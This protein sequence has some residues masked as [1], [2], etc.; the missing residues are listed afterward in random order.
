MDAAAS[1]KQ[2]FPPEDQSVV[3]HLGQFVLSLSQ[4]FS[5]TGYYRPGQPT[6]AARQRLYQEWSQL[7]KKD[8]EVSLI[9]DP[10][11]KGEGLLIYGILSEGT[12]LKA[13]FSE[14]MGAPFVPKFRDYF[15]SRRLV[16]FSLKPEIT[17]EEFSSF[18]EIMSEPPLPTA[19]RERAI[20]EMTEK[21]IAGQIV[22][23]SI[24]HLE[25]FFAVSPDFNWLTRILLARLQE[26]LRM[27]PLHKQLSETEK[28]RC[29]VR[30]FQTVLRP[31]THTAVL[32][33]ILMQCGSVP[34]PVGTG[35]VRLEAEICSALYPAQQYRLLSACA[36]DL[37]RLAPWG[38]RGSMPAE[39]ESAYQQTVFIIRQLVPQFV[40]VKIEEGTEALLETLIQ[41][42]IVAESELSASLIQRIDLVR[43]ANRYRKNPEETWERLDA[44]DA[45]A[46]HDRVALLPVLL[47]QN[48][49]QLFGTL[50][51]QMRIRFQ[52]TG[53]SDAAF[54]DTAC[55]V[56]LREALLSKLADRRLDNRKELLPIVEPF[57][58]L[59][60]QD[61]LPRCADEDIWLRRNLCRLLSTVGPAIIPDLI[62]IA[63][64]S[65]QD[66]Q[67]IR[68]IVMI[69]GDIGLPDE[70]ALQFLR[71]CQ[72]NPNR[73][74][75]EEVI[76]S[77][78]KIRGTA[79]E[80][81]LWQVLKEKDLPLRRRAVLAFGR[82]NPVPKRALAFFLETVRKRRK[83]DAPEDEQVEVNCCVAIEAMAAFDFPTAQSFEP[84]LCEA[85][86]P[87]KRLL[88]F[89]GESYHEKGYEVRK[90]MGRLLGVIGTKNA[91]PALT[92]L[93]AD[94]ALLPQ[95]REMMK[96]ALQKIE[97]I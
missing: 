87:E 59:L 61:M 92:L 24:V 26:E 5:K 57:A 60:V 64:E 77:Y 68:N 55:R 28:E 13:I 30:V 51:A 70:A 85:I 91:Q 41:E 89:I 33:E 52:K 79:V 32:K 35:K 56:E 54:Y 71:R 11:E 46:D 47:A 49:F 50:L 65:K 73:Q 9:I 67:F 53:G 43:K 36:D 74:V 34:F 18:I 39:K 75:Q 23:A 94:K 7:D 83:K 45:A 38:T 25:S 81:F 20:A 8:R 95:D 97:R 1:I 84:A 44:G 29:R 76:E 62:A 17:F 58:R 63:R 3:G 96:Q 37:Q 15:D 72:T 10:R 48:D 66:W 14:E 27:I 40:P 21:W 12:P 88:G 31:L 86:V 22:H 6:P 16:G 93:L 69:L 90:A 78:G 2:R 82:F 80:S 42:G 19:D 4:A